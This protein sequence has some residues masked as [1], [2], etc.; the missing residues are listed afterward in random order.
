MKQEDELGVLQESEKKTEKTVMVGC[1]ELHACR[2]RMIVT[3][4]ERGRGRKRERERKGVI[5]AMQIINN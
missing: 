3:S 2:A 1:K 4:I 5:N